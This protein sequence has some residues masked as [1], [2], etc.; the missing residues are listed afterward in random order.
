LQMMTRARQEAISVMTKKACEWIEIDVK[1]L[2]AS[3]Q[4][5]AKD[6][7]KQQKV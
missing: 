1:I 4:A 6:K 7:E 5:V 2:G 3:S